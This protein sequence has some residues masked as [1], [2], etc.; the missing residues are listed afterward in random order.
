[1]QDS[2]MNNRHYKVNEIA[3]MWNLSHDVVQRMFLNEPGVIR[4]K[5][6]KAKNNRS[7]AKLLIPESVLDRVYRSMVVNS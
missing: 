3:K 5:H 1:M 4:Y 6:A 7:Y 2:T